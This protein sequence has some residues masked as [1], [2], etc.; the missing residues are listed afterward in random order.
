[1]DL[2]S[3][4]H[5]SIFD[6]RLAEHTT[7]YVWVVGVVVLPSPTSPRPLGVLCSLLMILPVQVPASSFSTCSKM[8]KVHVFVLASRCVS[9]VDNGETGVCLELV[10]VELLVVLV[11]F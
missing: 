10:L 1:M 4:H 11:M 8:S 7:V 3:V 9:G 6:C 5:D 2:P